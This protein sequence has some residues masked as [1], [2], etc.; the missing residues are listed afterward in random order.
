MPATGGDVMFALDDG[1]LWLI[2]LEADDCKKIALSTLDGKPEYLCVSSAAKV[3][4]FSETMFVY[5]L[6]QIAYQRWD[7]STSRIALLNGT[8]SRM[9]RTEYGFRISPSADSLLAYGVTDMNQRI[10]KLVIENTSNG[11][12]FEPISGEHDMRGFSWSPDGSQLAYYGVRR[13]PNA[14]DLRGE[15]AVISIKD[16]TVRWVE[17]L[18][19][20]N[21]LAAH[22]SIPVYW[23]SDGCRIYLMQAKPT[24]YSITW[25]EPFGKNCHSHEM[26]L[27]NHNET[28]I[29][30]TE[31][32]GYIHEER[33]NRRKVYER[34][35]EFAWN[36][37]PS[38]KWQIIHKSEGTFC[39][40]ADT[41]NESKLSTD[42]QLKWQWSISS[43]TKK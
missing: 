7:R 20:V 1:Q 5:D 16:W 9:P 6:P 29:R 43:V 28:T 38:G 40:N 32:A 31:R 41:G 22:S 23:S 26:D 17:Q 4:W 11:Q 2:G 30:Y 13:A 25:I 19:D 42:A 15:L 34:T 24:G 36:V 39:R 3:T 37:S 33:D 27:S 12:V 8:A 35:G 18:F 10:I 14:K 21:A